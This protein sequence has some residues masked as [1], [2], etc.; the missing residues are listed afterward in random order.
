MERTG[1]LMPVFPNPDLKSFL[2]LHVERPI[3][4]TVSV[5][6]NTVY[7]VPCTGPDIQQ[8]LNEYTILHWG[9]GR[10]LTLLGDLL[11][12]R[13]P[14]KSFSHIHHHFVFHIHTVH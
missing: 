3:F 7:P 10:K 14:M 8:A 1:Q 6:F 4:R 9:M 2:M 5:L 12:A 11:C 13:S